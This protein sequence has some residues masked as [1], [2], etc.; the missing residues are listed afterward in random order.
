ETKTGAVSNRSSAVQLAT[1][2]ACCSVAIAPAPSFSSTCLRAAA[3]S[4]PALPSPES[5]LST[6]PPDLATLRVM[7]LEDRFRPALRRLEILAHFSDGIAAVF[8]R[9]GFRQ[10]KAEHGL[11][12]D[13][14]CRHG[15]D[16]AAH[17]RRRR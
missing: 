12:D 11:A 5:P 15:A 8:F 7:P 9:E 2:S 1:A 13:R 14:S 3:M 16:V 10:R 4:S 17:D 6:A